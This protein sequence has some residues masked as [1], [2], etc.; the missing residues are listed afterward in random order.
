MKRG[1]KSRRSNLHSEFL[2]DR[3]LLNLRRS[4]S[5][6]IAIVLILV[7]IISAIAIFWSAVKKNVEKSEEIDIEIITADLKI[8]KSRVFINES[9]EKLQLSINRGADNARLSSLKI[10]VLN[11]DQERYTIADIPSSLESKTYVLNISSINNIKEIL[12]YPVSE[13]GMIGTGER[14][15]VRGDEPE[16]IEDLDV[17][18]PDNKVS[19]ILNWQ[20]EEWSECQAVYDLNNILEEEVVLNGVQAR[21]CEDANNCLEKTI[22]IKEC[23]PQV[24]VNVKKIE[25]CD[26]EYLEI[27]D[28]QEVLISRLELING[29]L[30]IQFPLDKY[31]YFPYCYNSLQDCD[32]TGVDCGGSCNFCS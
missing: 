9:L 26:K 30:N 1:K 27:Y 19:C 14:Y 17:I 24:S 21:N 31:E 18:N 16:E 15:E 32:E 5:G 10:V 22:E 20:C 2:S 11:G 3:N 12:V 8:E 4:Q 13:K 7:I 25:K 23:N 28:L 6:I 29:R